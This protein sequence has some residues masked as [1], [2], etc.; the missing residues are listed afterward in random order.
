M[1]TQT[2]KDP[3]ALILYALYLQFELAEHLSRP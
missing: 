3:I 2:K 1:M